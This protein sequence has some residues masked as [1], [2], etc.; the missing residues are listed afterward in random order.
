VQRYPAEWAVALREMIAA[1]PELLVPAHGLPISGRQRI[2][3]VLGDIATALEDLVAAVIAMMN[4]ER[5]SMRSSTQC[6]FL[7]TRWPSR[8]SDRCTTNQSS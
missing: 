1:G 6:R 3:T 5:R 4:Q 8:I 7:P 2:A